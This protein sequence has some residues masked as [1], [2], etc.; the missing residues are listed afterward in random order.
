MT[1][2]AAEP[3]VSPHLSLT[4]T[5][6][7]G[8]GY[9][10]PFF[11]A[12]AQGRLLGTRCPACGHTSVPMR[13]LCPVDAHVMQQVELPPVA[14]LAQVTTGPASALLAAG[15]ALHTFGLVQITGAD[16]RLLVRIL[17]Q[18]RLPR[19]G[20]QVYLTPSRAPVSHPGHNLLF[21]LCEP[22]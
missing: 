10:A 19:P 3:D 5:W 9:L 1:G 22:D 8:L 20:D 4:L 18:H 15:P 11:A 2:T 13:A 17:S 21:T 16:N 6:Q 14:V 7:H 12:L